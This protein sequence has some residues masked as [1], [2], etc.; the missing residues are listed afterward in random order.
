MKRFLALTLAAMF[1]CLPLLMT[2]CGGTEVEN[3]DGKTAS[4]AY[5]GSI[6]IMEDLG[7][8]EIT[9][10]IKSGLKLGPVK[11]PFVNQKKAVKHSYDGDKMS[12]RASDKYFDQLMDVDPDDKYKKGIC[13]IDDKV[14]ILNNDDSVSSYS[15]GTYRIE[16]SEYQ[17]AVAR[18]LRNEIADATCYKDMNGYHFVLEL[19]EDDLVMFWDDDTCVGE[20]YTVYID[21]DGRL[22]KIVVDV[23]F[24]VAFGKFVST[25][26]Y[27]G[28]DPITVP[29]GP[30]DF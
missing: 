21:E 20:T 12:Y 22:T 5:F 3:I 23:D 27:D 6:E 30:E 16:E 28:L 17:D 25:Y 26:T 14:Y 19:E 29:E 7:R 10:D 4:E 1:L 2:S 9:V 8:H 11:V 24:G 15:K 18:I 13:E